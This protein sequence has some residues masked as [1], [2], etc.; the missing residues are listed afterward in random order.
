MIA[1]TNIHEPR[2]V[3]N[4]IE[5]FEKLIGLDNFYGFGKSERSVAYL[6]EKN[7]GLEAIE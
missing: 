6:F 2:L 4:L 5:S 1:G 7:G 3:E